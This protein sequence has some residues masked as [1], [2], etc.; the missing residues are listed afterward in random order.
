MPRRWLVIPTH[1][2]AIDVDALVPGLRDAR[3]LERLAAGA[4]GLYRDQRVRVSR[5][6]NP[7]AY[8]RLEGEAIERMATLRAIRLHDL[9]VLAADAA[10]EGAAEG[11]PRNATE[12]A[13]KKADGSPE[14]RR[15]PP[16]LLRLNAH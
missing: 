11:A 2:V 15:T 12:N 4:R 6:P 10:V 8:L 13:A 9:Q 14:G 1:A 5:A 16:S 7:L 3:R